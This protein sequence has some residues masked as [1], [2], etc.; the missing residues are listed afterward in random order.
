MIDYHNP[1]AFPIIPISANQARG[2][3][4]GRRFHHWGEVGVASH[5]GRTWVRSKRQRHRFGQCHWS[6][7]AVGDQISAPDYPA[8]G[9]CTELSGRAAAQIWRFRMT[10][11]SKPRLD[12]TWRQAGRGNPLPNL[13]TPQVTLTARQ[14]CS[15]TMALFI[16]FPAHAR[17]IT[18]LGDAQ[19]C[20]RLHTKIYALSLA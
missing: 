20:E 6:S 13:S 8:K 3:A 12:D 10:K 1:G 16:R 14:G 11:A 4:T 2:G 18:H 19:P 15:N 5:R 9:R 17:R 7:R